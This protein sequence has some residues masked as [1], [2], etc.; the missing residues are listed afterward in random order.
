LHAFSRPC[1]ADDKKP[2]VAAA[3]VYFAAIAASVLEQAVADDDLPRIELREEIKIGEKVLSGVAKAAGINDA[4]YA[5]FKDAGIRG[6]YNISLKQLRTRKGV[7]ES[8]VLYDFMGSTELAGNYFRITQTAERIRTKGIRGQQPLQDAAK[9]I[10]K[11]VRSTMLQNSGV[12]PENL[13]ISEDLNKVK[14]R[15]KSANRRM[16]KLDTM[17]PVA[18]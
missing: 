7:G 4:G 17:Y 11:Q 9:T 8:T 5:F 16:L 13:P 14:T 6:M 1:N 2:E 15:L 18:K 3:K 12:A 10:G